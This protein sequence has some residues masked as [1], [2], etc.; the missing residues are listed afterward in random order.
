MT[1][2]VIA[3]IAVLLLAL[4]SNLPSTTASPNVAGQHTG[5][6]IALASLPEPAFAQNLA[7]PGVGLSQGEES[8]APAL[9]IYLV[10]VLL[11]SIVSVALVRR[12]I[13]REV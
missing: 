4:S 13:G 3:L 8:P 9:L 1:R 12:G 7:A 5:A 2:L 10:F 11:G 6:S